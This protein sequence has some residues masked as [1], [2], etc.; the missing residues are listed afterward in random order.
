MPGSEIKY[1]FLND[2]HHKYRFFSSEPLHKVQIRFSRWQKIWGTAKDKLMLLP[3]RF[4]CREQAFERILDQKPERVVIHYAEDTSKHISRRFTF[5]LQRQRTLH[6]IFLIL[7]TLL[8]PLSG[9][10]AFIPGPNVFFAALALIMITQWRALRGINH[11]IGKER[12]FHASRLLKEW[13]EAV[14]EQRQQEYE[15]ILDRISRKWNIEKLNKI[16]LR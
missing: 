12:Q 13:N 6:I 9:L 10:M 11:L 3:A 4:L 2:T 15:D 16:L 14:R 1:F 5:Y 8:L 7:E